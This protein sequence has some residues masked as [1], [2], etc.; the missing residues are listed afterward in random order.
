MRRWMTTLINVEKYVPH[1]LYVANGETD[2]SQEGECALG[3]QSGWVPI[4]TKMGVADLLGAREDRHADTTRND[5]NEGGCRRDP[6][7]PRLR[8]PAR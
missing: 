7:V 5:R 8:A 3:D 6:P 4:A 1:C 2:L